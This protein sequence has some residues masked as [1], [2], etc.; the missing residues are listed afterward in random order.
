MEC[1]NNEESKYQRKL[2]KVSTLELNEIVIVI[3]DTNAICACMYKVA[4]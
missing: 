2:L 4:I 1:T 3:I